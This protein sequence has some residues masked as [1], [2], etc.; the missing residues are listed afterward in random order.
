MIYDTR[1]RTNLDKLADHTKIAAYKWYQ[2]CM[3][4]QIQVL[5]YETIRTV[6]QQKQ[7]VANGKSQTMKSY[8]LVGQALDW[9]LVDTKGNTLWNDYKTANGM[10]VINYAKSI[11]FDSGHDWGWDSPHLQYNYNGYGTDTFGKIKVDKGELTMTQFEQL[12][13]RIKELEAQVQNKANIKSD[14]TVDQSHRESWNWAIAEGII[15]GDGKS[16][17]PSGALSRQQM[18]TML[19]RYH[20]KLVK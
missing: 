4:N 20:D 14:S 11:G 1:N 15:K 13:A 6:A 8:H 2:Y 9:V 17:N 7:N 18:A 19:K 16:M 10:K 5:I 12:S 3:D